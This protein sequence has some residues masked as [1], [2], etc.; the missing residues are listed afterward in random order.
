MDRGY[1]CLVRVRFSVE[2]SRYDVGGHRRNV[3]LFGG[4][5]CV[6]FGVGELDLSRVHVIDQLAAEHEVDADDVVVEFVNDVHWVSKFLSFDL[7]VHLI[8]PYGI[9]CIS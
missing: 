5:N 4:T 1:V 9:H 2:L 6:H 7:E 8:D 3:H